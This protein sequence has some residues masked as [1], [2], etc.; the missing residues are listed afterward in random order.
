MPRKPSPETELRTLRRDLREM[1]AHKAEYQR[2]A[3]ALRGQLNKAQAETGEWRRRFD[4][5][6][7]K[8]KG[9]EMPPSET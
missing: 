7:L 5:V 9:F 6:L 2:E 8:C 4:Q 1:T 3:M